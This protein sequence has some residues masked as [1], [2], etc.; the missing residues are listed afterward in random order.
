VIEMFARSVPGV[1]DIAAQN[2]W[3]RIHDRAHA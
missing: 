1:G 2:S 3:V